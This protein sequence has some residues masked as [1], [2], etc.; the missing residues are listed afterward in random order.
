MDFLV[1][2]EHNAENLQFYLWYKD[3][4][5]RFEALPEK[6]RV[7]SPE[8]VPEVAEPL[9]LGKDAEKNELRKKR[10][11]TSADV[12]ELSNHNDMTLFK[13]DQK[14]AESF[15]HNFSGGIDSER[16]SAPT[17][18]SLQSDT[19]GLGETF[20]HGGLSQSNLQWQPCSSNHALKTLEY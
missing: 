3:Y 6:D 1:Y 15:R 7:L 2:V 5:R 13:P 17:T 18:P 12:L 4:V 10:T 14:E 9:N 19:R 16:A 20:S 8:W 11:A